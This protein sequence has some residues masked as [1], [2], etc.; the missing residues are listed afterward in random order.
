MGRELHFDSAKGLVEGAFKTTLTAT[1][2]VYT[3]LKCLNDMS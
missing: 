2:V 3:V 1:T